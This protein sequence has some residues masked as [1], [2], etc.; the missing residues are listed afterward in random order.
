M[1]KKRESYLTLLCK[2]DQFPLGWIWL[3]CNC[4]DPTAICEWGR[5]GSNP[6]IRRQKNSW[7][8]SN[9]RLLSGENHFDSGYFVTIYLSSIDF[10]RPR[11]KSQDVNGDFPIIVAISGVSENSS[12]SQS[13]ICLSTPTVTILS[14][15]ET[16]RPRTHPSWAWIFLVVFRLVRDHFLIWPSCAPLQSTFSFVGC[17]AIIDTPSEE[18]TLGK[19]TKKKTDQY[20]LPMRRQ[21]AW[22]W[23]SPTSVHL[24]LFGTLWLFPTDCCFWKYFCGPGAALSSSP[25]C[26]VMDFCLE[27]WYLPFYDFWRIIKSIIKDISKL[28]LF[29]RII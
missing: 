20:V 27:S 15:F 24:A 19:I 29:D 10:T 12:P 8:I 1:Y 23:L 13:L 16:A 11:A 6:N 3:C 5:I 18:V 28:L 25:A 4:R 22:P 2:Q 14:V 21:T 9:F 26:S 7:G 17:R